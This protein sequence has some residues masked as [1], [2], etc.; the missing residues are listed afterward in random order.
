MPGCGKGERGF[1][2]GLWERGTRRTRETKKLVWRSAYMRGGAQ[3]PVLRA[4][5]S[6]LSAAHGLVWMHRGT[7]TDTHG[8]TGRHGQTRADTETRTDTDRHR[9]ARR[10]GDIRRHGDTETRRHGDTRTHTDTYGHTRIHLDTYTQGRRDRAD[11]G[12]H[13]NGD[14]LHGNTSYA[15]RDKQV[16]SRT[17]PCPGAS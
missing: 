11:G 10:H 13:Y 6:L 12:D 8:H 16:V 3:D 4:R 9:H 5:G 1:R 15:Q 2:I 14:T 17:C 7:C